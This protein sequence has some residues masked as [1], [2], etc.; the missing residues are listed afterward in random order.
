MLLEP[1][2][3]GQNHRFKINFQARGEE[4]ISITDKSLAEISPFMDIIGI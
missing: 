1:Q 3:K 2:F 4:F